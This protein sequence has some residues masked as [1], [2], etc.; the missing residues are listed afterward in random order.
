MFKSKGVMMKNSIHKYY[1]QKPMPA[2]DASARRL[3]FEEQYSN[4]YDDGLNI[5]SSSCPSL[6]GYDEDSH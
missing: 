2:Y 3:D 5:P 1:Q 6:D 4:D